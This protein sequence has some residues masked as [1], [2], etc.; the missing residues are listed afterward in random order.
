MEQRTTYITIRIDF[1][2]DGRFTNEGGYD[3]E[4]IDAMVGQ[5]VAQ[6]AG[7]HSHTKEDGIIIDNIEMCG[8][9]Y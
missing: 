5:L 8:V 6:R 2:H 4:D 9:N 1:S 3:T 7:Y